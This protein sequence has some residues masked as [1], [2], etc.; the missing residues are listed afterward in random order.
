[1]ATVN[2]VVIVDSSHEGE[3]GE[4]RIRPLS[5]SAQPG[6][7]GSHYV[8]PE[9]LAALTA[10]VYGQCPPIMLSDRA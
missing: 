10:A 9:E 8:T 1:M 6:A 7:L 5:H 4:L 2:L 3:T